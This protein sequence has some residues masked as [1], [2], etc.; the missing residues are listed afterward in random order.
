MASPGLLEISL[1]V[2]LVVQIAISVVI[3]LAV[4]LIVIRVRRGRR[5]DPEGA[6]SSAATLNGGNQ[7]I[8]IIRTHLGVSCF[9]LGLVLVT[10]AGLLSPGGDVAAAFVWQASALVLTVAIYVFLRRKAATRTN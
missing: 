7:G 4:V 6:A 5:R 3:A 8:E 2:G 9:V 10:L 1:M